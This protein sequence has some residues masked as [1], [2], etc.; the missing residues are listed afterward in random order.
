MRLGID[1]DGV[2]ANFIKGWMD[3][4]NTEYGARLTEELVDSW[5]AAGDL[6]H[7]ES[8]DDF[9][10]WA[11]AS[12]DGPTV[13]RDLDPYPGALRALNQLAGCH[14]IVIL[15]MKPDWAISDTYRWIADRRIPTTEVHFLRDKWLVDCD[16]YLDDSPFAL[17]AL[18]A[19]RP[20]S[21]VC[22]FVRSYNDP[23]A[24]AIDIDNWDQF[25]SLVRREN[26]D[27]DCSKRE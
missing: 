22:R 23:V 16:V 3:R 9:W 26:D 10:L 6:T 12:G 17:P 24:G 15:S 13:F 18:V 7:F 4:Y 21:V 14:D 8:L 20:S 25:V 1:L 19:N 2:V 5:D 27:R 11:G